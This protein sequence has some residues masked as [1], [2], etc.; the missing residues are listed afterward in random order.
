MTAFLSLLPTLLQMLSSLL[1]T[2]TT[3]GG[4][5]LLSPHVSGILGAVSTLIQQGEDAFPKFE[6]LTQH[7]VTLV[8]GGTDPTPEQVST[9]QAHIAAAH[10]PGAPIPVVPTAPT[11]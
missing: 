8:K 7:V 3:A 4:P 5:A 9:L 1:A 10:D 11:S 2:P 6:A